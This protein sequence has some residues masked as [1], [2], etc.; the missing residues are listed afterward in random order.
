GSE[1]LAGLLYEYNGVEWSH[2]TDH[3]VIG[4]RAAFGLAYQE[5]CEPQAFRSPYCRRGDP[6]L[7]CGRTAPPSKRDEAEADFYDS[8]LPSVR[9]SIA[10]CGQNNVFKRSADA[11]FLDIGIND[12]GF[13]RWVAG[14]I[15]T[16]PTLRYISNAFVPCFDSQGSCA[17]NFAETKKLYDTLDRRYA[18]LRKVLDQFLLPDFGI[19]PSHVIV[20]IYPP[21]L[22]N[23]EGKLCPQGNAGLTVAT[24]ASFVKNAHAC[25]GGLVF[26]VANG[27]ISAYPTGEAPMREGEEAR[28]KLNDSLRAF[29][30]NPEDRFDLI[31]AYESRF[32]KRGVCA[33]QDAASRPLQPNPCFDLQDLMAVPCAPG[34][35]PSSPES[36][37]VPR[38]VT[39]FES[40]LPNNRD[41]SFFHPF[42]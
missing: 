41:P 13:S 6:S 4:S 21:G 3:G 39:H 25:E 19:A 9:R 18:L 31:S 23:E 22:E 33:T 12:V 34:N 20:P 14:L 28:Q 36:M 15:L 24:F 10:R 40:C 2:A 38:T 16:D 30:L 27:V 17:Q 37:H 32:L 1:I 11:L 35:P 8:A 7:W 42:P 26:G 29:V 5:M